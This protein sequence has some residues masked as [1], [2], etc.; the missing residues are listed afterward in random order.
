MSV[1]E[2]RELDRFKDLLENC[3][4]VNADK[5]ITPEKALQHDF[6]TMAKTKKKAPT[7]KPKRKDASPAP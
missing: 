5:R 1:D 2:K 6:F 3:L 4:L 7:E